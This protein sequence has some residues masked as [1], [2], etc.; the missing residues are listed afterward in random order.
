MQ[1]TGTVQRRSVRA[2]QTTTATAI[3]R[4]T[5]EWDRARPPT[6]GPDRRWTSGRR[7]HSSHAPGTI[8]A[9]TAMTAAVAPSAMPRFRHSPRTANQSK[10]IPGVTLVNRMSAQTRAGQRKLDDDRDRQQQRDVAAGQFGGREQHADREQ[11]R[12]R[13]VADG[14]HQD[15]RPDPRKAT[16]GERLS[17]AMACR[18]AGE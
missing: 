13:Q 1:A 12:A 8:A 6:S 4:R 16:Q 18:N 3:G 9:E 2:P 17:G 14:H 15:R 7:S 11:P 10:P 5:I